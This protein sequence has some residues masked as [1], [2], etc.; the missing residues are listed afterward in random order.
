[1]CVVLDTGLN[2][3]RYLIVVGV[4]VAVA[5]VSILLYAV[6][7]THRP[8][9]AS[10][11]AE[12]E[13]VLPG[14]S[15]QIVCNAT[16]LRGDVL[17]Y[18]WSATGGEITGQGAMVMWTAPYSEGSYSV[19]VTVTD[20]HGGEA[21]DYVTIVVGFNSAP[22]IH[23]MVANADW[24]TP[25]GSL[26]IT[27]DASDPDGDELSYEWVASGGNIYG[28]GAVVDWTAPEEVGLYNIT[29][30]VRDGYGGEDM[31]MLT[32]GV[33]LNP[34]P[35]I[36]KL[37]VTPRG[38]PYLR[39]PSQPGCD[40]DVWILEEYDIECVASNTSGELVYNWSCDGGVI[41]GAGS[42]ITWTAPDEKTSEARVTVVVSVD[43]NSVAKNIVFWIPFCACGS[44]G[45]ESLEISF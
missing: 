16:A 17:T 2:R 5:L 25:S 35:T 22:T 18:N 43:G 44:W 21:G 42:N 9:I 7:A 15:S 39:E 27:C 4:V 34:P 8:V 13:K 41:S 37:V 14:G 31:R 45:L 11:V 36:E 26:W 38:N 1:M 10:L 32:L 28:A 30:V 20:S 19:T 12:P 6:L 24:V 40:C 33:A 29:V 3:K 23:S